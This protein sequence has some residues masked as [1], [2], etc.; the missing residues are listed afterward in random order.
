MFPS[1]TETQ[2]RNFYSKSAKVIIFSRE[3]ALPPLNDILNRDTLLKSNL[4]CSILRTEIRK[5][6]S[7]RNQCR[8]YDVRRRIIDGV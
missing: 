4:V 2:K 6:F 7:K 8:F 3:S 1:D 5:S